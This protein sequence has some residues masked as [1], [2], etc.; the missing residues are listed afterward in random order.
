[1]KIDRTGCTR[2]VFV[3]NRFVVKVPNFLDG[4]RLFLCGLLANMQERTFSATEWDELCPVLWSTP[5]GWLVVMQR[6]RVMTREE[7]MEFDFDSFISKPDYV[8]PVEAK[9]N[10][11]GYL[12]NKVV[13]I[14]YGS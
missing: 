10:S 14:D 5:G 7:F 11:F 3:C 6:A 13:A 9:S 1:M 4:W 2:I 12:N 8:I